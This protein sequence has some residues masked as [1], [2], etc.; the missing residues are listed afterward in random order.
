MVRFLRRVAESAAAAAAAAATAETAAAAACQ[1]DVRK[2]RE[3]YASGTIFGENLVNAAAHHGH[4]SVLEYLFSLGFSLEFQD[5]DGN[6]PAHNGIRHLG[7][8]RYLF[9]KG[10]SMD[11]TNHAGFTSTEVA[12][13]HNKGIRT[14]VNLRPFVCRSRFSLAVA[15]L[16][17]IHKS[18]AYLIL[19][20]HLLVCIRSPTERSLHTMQPTGDRA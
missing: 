13:Q 19:S 10:V 12:A 16:G 5:P 9:E 20:A 7:V 8:M 6:T 1:G 4:V 15:Q 11:T 3:L 17:G 14:F 18:H 2:L